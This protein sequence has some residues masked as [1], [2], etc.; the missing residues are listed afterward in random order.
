ME[1]FRRVEIKYMLSPDEYQALLELIQPNI[2]QDRYFASTNCSIYF[3]TDHKDLVIHSMEKPL[4]K[5]KLRLRSYNVPSMDDTV[6]VEIKRK[7]SGVGSK[8]RISVKLKDFYRYLETGELNSTSPQI[9]SEIDY[10]IKYHQLKPKLFLAYDRNSYCGRQDHTFRLTF[11]RN[12]RSRETDLRLEDGDAGTPFFD[13]D[14]I[15]METKTLD[16]YPLWFSHA[17]AQLKIY[18][19]SFSKYGK[20]YQKIMQLDEDR[21]CA[22]QDEKFSKNEVKYQGVYNV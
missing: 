12:I 6:F 3:D 13:D 8:R 21:I 2:E 1:T 11:D 20:V 4:Y 10:C 15:I 17:L 5:E 22:T 14:T 9:K 19:A 18:P 16:A 7:F